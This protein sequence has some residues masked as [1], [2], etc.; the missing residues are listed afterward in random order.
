MTSRLDEVFRGSG[1]S[2]APEGSALL[3]AEAGVNHNG[4]EALALKLVEAAAA[5]GVDAVKF[6]T[7]VPESLVAARA[8]LAEYQRAGTNS[9][10]QLS[11]LRELCLGRESYVRL[12]QAAEGLGLAFM[13]TPFDEESAIFLTALGVPALKISSGEVTNLPF[14]SC[15]A[16]LGPP[17]ILS[18]GMSTME[19]VRAAVDTVASSGAALA[20]LHCVSS[21]PTA[22]EDCNL[23]AMDTMRQTFDLPVGWSDH[24]L[25][26]EVA[27]AAA[28]LGASIIEKHITLDRNMKGPDHQASTEPA[29]FA[30]LVRSIRA[31]EASRGDGVKRPRPSEI[32]VARVARRSLHWAR[33]LPAG[34]VVDAESLVCLRPEGGLAPAMLDKLAGRQ[35]LRAVEKGAQTEAGDLFPR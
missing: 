17:L 19:E 35:L 3:I 9:A 20:L 7:F 27:L 25:G 24:T 30:R 23:R 22:P 5:A 15:V 6:Q 26:S 13:S 2:L 14:L 4:D 31:V 10:D 1:R 8:P 29:E 16:K 18:T 11:M 28:A 21:Y 33:D 32:G 12:K 34:H